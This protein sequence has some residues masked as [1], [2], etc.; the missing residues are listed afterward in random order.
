MSQIDEY[1]KKYQVGSSLEEYKKKYGADKYTYFERPKIEPVVEELENKSF[2]DKYL[3]ASNWMQEKIAVP[4]VEKTA[5]IGVGLARFAGDIVEDIEIVNKKR[6]ELAKQTPFF[7]NPFLGGIVDKAVEIMN[8][9]DLK[10]SEKINRFADEADKATYQLT[11]RPEKDFMDAVMQG[12]GSTLPFL[13][14]GGYAKT[15][16]MSASLAEGTFAGGEA[17]INAFSD[18]KK[19]AEEGDKNASLKGVASFGANIAVNWLTNKFGGFFQNTQKGV[20]PSLKRFLSTTFFETGQETMQQVISNITTGEKVETGTLETALVSLPI[21]AIFGATGIAI[22]NKSEKELINMI[23]KGR[24]SGISNNTITDMLHKL[25][26][27]KKEDIQKY[28][29]N[30]KGSEKPT[31]EEIKSETPEQTYKSKLE[32]EIESM[33]SV[34]ENLQVNDEHLINTVIQMAEESGNK[35]LIDK[36]NKAIKTLKNNQEELIKRQEEQA[37]I[38]EKS[39]PSADSELTNPTFIPYKS[40]RKPT[41]NAVYGNTTSDKFIVGTYDGKPYTTNAYI[42]EF[43]SDVTPPSKAILFNET[44]GA[45]RVPDQA[46]IEKLIP[47][48][49]APVELTKV[50]GEEGGKMEFATLEGENGSLNIQRKYYDY[51]NNKYKNPQFFAGK[52]GPILVMKGDQ[53]VGLIMPMVNDISIK[54]PVTVWEKP[55]TAQPELKQQEV[56]EKKT[57]E[58]EKAIVP[59]ADKP[60]SKEELE[61]LPKEDRKDYELYLKDKIEALPKLKEGEITVIFGGNAKS[62]YVDTNIQI[63]LNRGVNANTNVMNVLEE[64]LKIPNAERAER[65]ERILEMKEGANKTPLEK[66]KDARTLAVLKERVMFE[67]KMMS[68]EDIFSKLMAEGYETKMEVTKDF[69]KIQKLQDQYDDA[70]NVAYGIKGRSPREKLK[71]ELDEAKAKEITTY[72]LTNGKQSY[73]L[74]KLEYDALQIKEWEVG[75][76][77]YE[78]LRNEMNTPE[79]IA[80]HKKAGLEETG[81]EFVGPIIWNGTQEQWSKYAELKAKE[82]AKQVAE[83]PLEKAKDART[84]AE[85]SKPKL[86]DYV[87]SKGSESI[88]NMELREENKPKEGTKQFKIHQSVYDL[89]KKYNPGKKFAEGHLPHGSAGVRWGD[90]GNINT[91]GLNN[92]SVATHELSHALDHEYSITEELYKKIGESKD[93]NPIYDPLTYKERKELTSVY[94]TFYY[95]GKKDHPLKTRMVEGYATFIQ[96]YIE[97]PITI[98]KNYPYLVEQFITPGGKYYNP[99]VNALIAESNLIISDYQNL[100]ALD[101]VGAFVTDNLTEIEKKSFLTPAESIYRE[102]TDELYVFEKLDTELADTARFFS[103]YVVNI[104]NQNMKGSIKIDLKNKKKFTTDESYWAIRNNEIKKTLPYNWKT[105]LDSLGKENFTTFGN[106]LVARTSYYDYKNLDK[107]K[108]IYENL[109]SDIKEA[110]ENEEEVSDEEYADLKEAKEQYIYYKRITEKDGIPREKATQGYL[111]NKEFYQEQLKMFDNLNKEKIKTLM[112]V[113]LISEKDGSMMLEEEGYSSRKRDLVNEIFG[114]NEMP[115][116][117]RVGNNK[118][119]FMMQR[120]G[121]SRAIINPLASAIVDEM[122]ASKKAAKQAV[123]NRIGEIGMKAIHPD[124]IQRIELKTLVDKDTGKITYPQEK[125]SNVVMARI[126]GKRVPF[127]VDKDIYNTYM[128]LVTPENIGVIG[129]T[130]QFF[131]RTF[132]KGTTGVLS[133]FALK[134]PIIDTFSAVINS[135]NNYIPIVDQIKELGVA[136]SNNESIEAQFL[137]EYLTLVAGSQ[138]RASIYDMTPEQQMEYITGEMNGLKKAVSLLEKSVDILTIPTQISEILTRSVE[139]IKARKNGNDFLRAAEMAGQVSAP[140]HHKPRFYGSTELKLWIGNLPYTRSSIQSLAQIIRSGGRDKET[141]ARLIAIIAMIV[142]A[143]IAAQ[144]HTMNNATEAQKR[145]YKGLYAKELARGI[146]FPKENG[147]DLGVIPIP[148]QLGWVSAF[149]NMEIMELMKETDYTIQDKLQTVT[150]AVPNIFNLTNGFAGLVTAWLPKPLD[151]GVGLVFNKKTF[152]AVIPIESES[153]L[154]LPPGFRKTKNSRWA[155]AVGKEFNISPLKIEFVVRGLLGRV[156]KIPLGDKSYYNLLSSFTQEEYFTSNRQIQEFFDDKKKIDQKY[157]TIKKDIDSYTSKEEDEILSL[158]K[159]YQYIYKKFNELN[160]I[161]IEAKPDTANKLRDEII[162]EID[163]L[164]KKK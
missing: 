75:G 132:T 99:K 129:R 40:A 143:Q 35:E 59:N 89:I 49:T 4:V 135:Q 62:Q 152:P 32:S 85:K 116:L 91:S 139:Y 140:F 102:L 23:K 77:K 111:E 37:K 90:T 78:K 53:K 117:V 150:A 8:V 50:Y 158:Y 39:I 46:T 18:Y 162:K 142:G 125:Q 6:K 54:K 81:I 24:G 28:V 82:S 87:V 153:Q 17:L 19:S 1:K 61:A 108:Q 127:M 114:E 30:V 83:S 55:K 57:K 45:N 98:T 141:L 113:G 106:L 70:S 36:V 33:I 133:T 71:A 92:L 128:E 94:T 160:D 25:F 31:E 64:D 12:F 110:I 11:G 126:N 7:I 72:K 10:L 42:L 56:V 105:L 29:E 21:S 159:D 22:P 88:G 151:V 149:V 96:K 138:T 164:D 67:G 95:G 34:I 124:L 148:E 107:Y 43:N 145:T 146:Y 130:I 76:S 144:R 163:K 16:G 38:I 58:K 120:R 26:G 134:N 109:E 69:K 2:L 122:E 103:N 131:G 74:K 101:A 66:A 161:D 112:D 3:N 63:A 123:L 48:E 121:S 5:G 118:L 97:H 14:G 100:S 119:S 115:S 84:S 47:K 52:Q 20:L 93:G 60:L 13:I 136:L 68:K 51:F 73:P 79:D 15:A 9:P 155:D 137:N 104:I 147:V 154:R 65:G 156:G 80:L 44:V 27:G 41:I 157:T 86:G